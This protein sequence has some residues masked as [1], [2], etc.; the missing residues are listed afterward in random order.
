MWWVNFTINSVARPVRDAAAKVRGARVTFYPDRV[1][2]FLSL[3]SPD[4]A[5]PRKA[6]KRAADAVRDRLRKAGVPARA[7]A[8]TN[9]RCVG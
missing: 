7:I 1:D 2:G 5:N 4:L 9:V 3:S 6:T 8:I